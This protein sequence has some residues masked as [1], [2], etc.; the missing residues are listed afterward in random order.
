[1]QIGVCCF[2]YKT[3]ITILVKVRTHFQFFC[4]CVLIYVLLNLTKILKS[5][6]KPISMR[7]NQKPILQC[8]VDLLFCFFCLH[9]LLHLFSKKTLLKGARS[10]LRHFL[11]TE[12]PLKTMN[13]TFYFTLKALFVLKIFKFLSWLFSHVEKRLD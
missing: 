10:G 2:I 1:M 6:T 7:V 3:C 8:F 13:N 9:V 11:A 12:S 5:M 4:L